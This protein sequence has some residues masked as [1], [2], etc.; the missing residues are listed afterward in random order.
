MSLQQHHSD[1]IPSSGGSGIDNYGVPY[2]PPYGSGIDNRGSIGTGMG[3]SG[4]GVGG[5]HSPTSYVPT[6]YVPTSKSPSQ[7][8][9][10]D[11]QEH[12]HQHQHQLEVQVPAPAPVGAPVGLPKARQD[13]ASYSP[14]SQIHSQ[15]Q[16]SRLDNHRADK[17]PTARRYVHTVDKYVL[18]CS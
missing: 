4:G 11:T 12:Q 16:S 15:S 2:S 17:S 7:T 13:T 6:S 1:D 10:Q 8:S 5:Q 18:F 14:N 9:A 3:G